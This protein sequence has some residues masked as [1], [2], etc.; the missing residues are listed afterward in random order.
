MFTLRITG[1]LFRLASFALAVLVPA[2]AAQAAPRP[3]TTPAVPTLPVAEVRAGQKAIVR[4]VMVGDSVETFEA[5]IVGVL[6]GGRAEGDLILARATS[7]SVERVGVAQGMSGSPVYVD[8]RLVGALSSGWIFSREPVFGITPI[9]DMLAVLD[10]PE[11]GAGEES[12][13]PSGVDPAASRRARVREYRW[14]DEPDEPLAPPVPSRASR[15]GALAVPLAVSGASPAVLERLRTMFEPEGFAVVPGGRERKPAP[16]ARRA[17]AAHRPEPGDAVAVDLLRGDLNLSAIGTVTYVDGDRV[18]IF[19]HPFFQSGEVRLPLSTAHIT[20]VIGS[21]ISSFK[22]GTPGTPI[23]TV[24]QDRRAAVA[25]R[26]GPAPA[27]LPFGVSVRGAGT[28]EERF[29]FETVEDRNLLP[30]LVTS[31]VANS[32]LESGGTGLLQTVH[33]SLDIWRAGRRL[34]LGDVVAGEAPLPEVLSAITAPIRFLSTNPYRRFAADS[35]AVR[36]DVRPGRAQ[37]TLRS[38]S[39]AQAS[40]RPGGVVRVQLQLERWRGAREVVELELPVPEEVPDGRYQLWLG[41]GLEADRFIAG[42]LPSRFRVVSL[43]DAWQ[44][45]GYA[46]RSDVLHAGLWAHAPEVNADG[47]DLPELPTSAIAVLSATQQA[48]E[49]SRRGDWALVQEVRVTRDHVVRGELLLELIV[50]RRAP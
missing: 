45:L 23:G 31:A 8:G 44:R 34:S 35:F 9:A 1:R 38:A 20:T 49:R 22:L 28:R 21:V 7:P 46:R 3:A 17:Q 41:G 30:Q 47:E 26:L 36:L 29:R 50:D 13:G 11:S 14:A 6:P 48:G 37:S 15:P 24:T 5:E 18:L 32:F 43:E 39:L 4:T 10:V 2:D 16:D 12:S 27:L 42:R 33:W 25:G 19:G 40:T